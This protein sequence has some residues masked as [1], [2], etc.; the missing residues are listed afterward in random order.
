MKAD[1]IQ[2]NYRAVS[3]WFFFFRDVVLIVRKG[4]C[5]YFKVADVIDVWNMQRNNYV[6]LDKSIDS[7]RLSI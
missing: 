1:L 4:L 6:M 3:I 5:I 7:Q 2:Q